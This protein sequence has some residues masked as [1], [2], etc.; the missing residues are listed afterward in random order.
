M[1]D[2]F[3]RC[4]KCGKRIVEFDG[5]NYTA[6]EVKY[7]LPL[8][9]ILGEREKAAGEILCG[10]CWSFFIAERVLLPGGEGL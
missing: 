10:A 6:P 2:V 9:R 3:Y 5:R 8:R 7:Q 4:G 1:A